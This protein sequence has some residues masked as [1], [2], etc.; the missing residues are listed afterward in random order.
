MVVDPKNLTVDYKK[1]LKSTNMDRSRSQGIPDLLSR[2]TP[3]ELASAFPE[4]IKQGGVRGGMKPGPGNAGGKNQ[5]FDKLSSGMTGGQQGRDTR[6]GV[7]GRAQAGRDRQSQPPQKQISPERQEVLNLIDKGSINASDPRAKFLQDMPDDK[8][9][10]MGIQKTQ[11]EAGE[12]IYKPTPR[13]SASITDEDAVKHINQ[14]SQ[15]SPLAIQRRSGQT[16]TRE[17]KLHI[18]ATALA[19]D[20]NPKGTQKV[21]ESGYNRAAAYG[22]G[23]TSTKIFG[24]RQSGSEYYSPVMKGHD[25]KGHQRYEEHYRRLANNPNEFDRMDR[26]HD[27]VIK[28]SNTANFATQ[29][30][31]GAVAVSARREQHIRSEEGGH[32]FSTKTRPGV[33]GITHPKEI[34]W[35]QKSQEDEK[36]FAENRASGVQPGGPI[37]PEKIAEVRGKLKKEADEAQLQNERTARLDTFGETRTQTGQ[38][39]TGQ[40][41]QT[42]QSGEMWQKTQQG[43][44]PA[45]FS[46]TVSSV[47][48][49]ARSHGFHA[50]TD[51]KMKRGSP[52]YARSDGIVVKSGIDDTRL[53]R[54]YGGTSGGIVTVRY[55]DGHV[56]KY[57]H[58]SDQYEK[59]GSIVKAGQI[60]KAGDLI[61]KSGIAADV[62]HVH[63]EIY[64]GK[65]MS[66][67][68]MKKIADSGKLSSLNIASKSASLVDSRNFYGVQKG[69]NVI[70]GYGGNEKIRL[71][72]AARRQQTAQAQPVQQQIAPSAPPQSPPQGQPV[73]TGPA[74][75][76]AP[77][78]SVTPSAPELN[79]YHVK[80]PTGTEGLIKDEL[81]RRLPGSK[82][83]P[84]T[85]RLDTH[86]TK[87]QLDQMLEEAGY[88][89]FKGNI[90][91]IKQPAPTETKDAG[92][93]VSTA[94]EPRVA[95]SPTRDPSISLAPLNK[96]SEVQPQ[97]TP[98]AQTV[99][100]PPPPPEE[101]TE[102]ALGG[103]I[104]GIVEPQ[105][106]KAIPLSQD[107]R[108]TG[109]REDT[110]ILYDGKVKATANRRE[111]IQ[112]NRTDKSLKITPTQRQQADTI[113]ETRNQEKREDTQPKQQQ[114]QMQQPRQV[115][116]SQTEE[117]RKTLM[118]R[119][120]LSFDNDSTQRAY[121]RSNFFEPGDQIAK[122]HLWG[123]GGNNFRSA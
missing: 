103:T 101:P 69:E 6:P 106:V 9:S 26:M 77:T 83:D 68:E 54:G 43:H 31:S 41:T 123:P 91:P 79:S 30:A 15:E 88:P 36:Q 37:S 73:Q 50:G 114:Q 100:S 38:T 59:G 16:L 48:G 102:E 35:L 25:P 13:K 23:P 29:N 90:T 72:E 98:P 60:V 55:T 121:A 107:N 47:V 45:S 5:L 80:A 64:A 70:A 92:L 119:S 108:T 40:P 10:G 85:G 53:N 56:E 66:I 44:Y 57:M 1:L 93:P 78:A 51:F 52:I 19:E 20:S 12:W 113:T 58:T 89:Q 62:P 118:Q 3:T 122:S 46:G 14:S 27:A 97:V 61:G 2:L 39:A 63:H 24:T 87:E 96:P 65:P 120:L 7:H 42:V 116:H 82:Y 109:A 17:E 32:I 75:S 86:H 34:E 110:A 74:K 117:M 71:A 8:L 115:Q 111:G 33:A 11:N 104:E 4:Y 105:K 95:A 18:Y 49:D 112:Y 28:G 76:V 21:L 67:D 81:E 94:I 22:Y 84:K 99:Q